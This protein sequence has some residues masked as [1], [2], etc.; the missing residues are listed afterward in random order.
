MFG[1]LRPPLGHNIL[2]KV[3]TDMM[4]EAG[5]EGHYSNHSLRASLATWLYDAEVDEQLIM[6][7][8]GKSSTEGVGAYKRASTKLKQV[9]SDV[10]NNRQRKP[11]KELTVAQQELESPKSILESPKAKRQCKENQIIPLTLSLNLNFFSDIVL[12]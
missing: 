6:S 5:Y 9:T 1:I 11:L 10:L 7:R 3:V 8:T 4:K 12:V 2:G